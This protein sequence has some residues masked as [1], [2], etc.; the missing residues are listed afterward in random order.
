MAPRTTRHAAPLDVF[1]LLLQHP[2]IVSASDDQTIRIWNWQNRSCMSVRVSP[3]PRLSFA[4]HA[5]M[6]VLTGHNHYV[7]SAS[8]HPRDDL[9][10][11]ASLDQSV[12]VWD[13]QARRGSV[14][15]PRVGLLILARR[16]CTPRAAAA[17]AMTGRAGDAQL[18]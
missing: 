14:A 1:A 12:R 8:F 2:W 6:Q 9:V 3:P 15:A 13:I 4:K 7:M 5:F 17:E 18:S 10:L 11:S 16:R